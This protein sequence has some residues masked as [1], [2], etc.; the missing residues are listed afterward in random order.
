MVTE[1]NRRKQTTCIAAALFLGAVACFCSCGGQV[2]PTIVE[3]EELKAACNYIGGG[4]AEA[5]GGMGGSLYIVSTLE[6][7]VDPAT[8][9]AVMGTLRYAVEQGDARIVMFRVSGV[10]HLIKP[11][12]I[13]RGNITIA[14]QTA[15]G[16][17]I[18]LADYPLIIKG[19]SNVIVRFIRVRMG[20][21]GSLADDK[22][23]DAVSVNDCDLVVLDHLSCSWSVDE[24]VSCY[25]NTRFTMQYCYVTESLRSSV[26]GKGNHG[27]G[28]IWGGENVSFHHNLLA[29]HD[30][31]NPR[32]DHDYVNTLTGPI[33]FIN[34]VVYNWGGNSCYGG[35][36]S[37][38]SGGG[39]KVNFIGNYFK[40]GP[41]TKSGVKTRLCNPST[42]CSNCTNKYGGSVIPMQMWLKGNTMYGSDAVTS[43]NWQGVHPDNAG[44]LADCKADSRFS[45][46]NAYTGEQT[47]DAA[48][49]T[50]LEKGGCS[51]VR[52]AIDTR[53][54]DE[55]NRGTYTYKGTSSTGGLIDTPSDVGGWP[56]Y[57]TGE[58]LKD[59]DGDGI[60]D[61]WEEAHNLNPKSFADSKQELLVIGKT[62]LECYLC[63]IVKDLY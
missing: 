6:D 14:G 26:H 49:T 33:D 52:D 11:L 15:P 42:S 56:S 32:F 3:D 31:R 24:C 25:G 59:T 48:L 16:D 55:V 35:E 34:N 45:F 58:V 7:E 9:K 51:L 1:M 2:T 41:A 19:C 18:C 38:K 39:R 54:A 50:V 63:D 12:E 13:T 22:E 30:S 4:G 20:E 10:I 46:T 27:Y 5:T 44:K 21:K 40:P 36:G 62:N 57:Q 60:P 43:D 61:E 53:I 37:S 23:Y 17:G 8:N 28:G 47:A 29:H